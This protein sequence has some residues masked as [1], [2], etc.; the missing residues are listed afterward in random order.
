MMEKINKILVANSGEIA[1]RIFRAC[2]ELNITY[3]GDLFAEKIVVL[4][5]DI[6]R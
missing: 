6:K 1:I 3:S 4:T 2:T 5:I